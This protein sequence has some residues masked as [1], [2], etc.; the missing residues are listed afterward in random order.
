MSVLVCSSLTFIVSGFLDNPLLSFYYVLLSLCY[1][2]L[3]LV[4][5]LLLEFFVIVCYSV[6]L[7]DSCSLFCVVFVIFLRHSDVTTFM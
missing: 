3:L 5:L 1:L 4:F 6:L 2:F 7:F